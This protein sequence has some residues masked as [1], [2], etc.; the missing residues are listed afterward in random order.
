[1]H[2]FL[3]HIFPRPSYLTC[4]R[5]SK[6]ALLP[7]IKE[8]K[9]PSL[10]AQVSFG[11]F[12]LKVAWSGKFLIPLYCSWSGSGMFIPM[13]SIIHIGIFLDA[14]QYPTNTS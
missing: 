11:P 2:L 5:V 10:S 3:F 13:D 6:L 1:M 7:R 8:R 4:C 14:N 9:T 12:S